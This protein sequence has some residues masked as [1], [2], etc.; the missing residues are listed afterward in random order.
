LVGFPRTTI[1]GTANLPETPHRCTVIARTR[2]ARP[3]VT[4]PKA[5]FAN[6][7]GVQS[8]DERLHA[9]H[10]LHKP[11][12]RCPQQG[13]ANGWSSNRLRSNPGQHTRTASL[14][15]KSQASTC[16]VCGGFWSYDGLCGSNSRIPDRAITSGLP[17]YTPRASYFA[18]R[19]HLFRSARA[20]F[21]N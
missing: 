4:V 1:L 9:N 8:G 19:N 11:C 20:H 21:A 5:A 16:D 7:P 15:S 3:H 17:T 18:Y 14:R 2:R 6:N 13:F 12:A 10:R